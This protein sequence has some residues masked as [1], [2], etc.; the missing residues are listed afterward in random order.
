MATKL[1]PQTTAP[2]EQSHAQ[3]PGRYYRCPG[4]GDEV[5]GTNY[6]VVHLHQ[7]H[8]L[9]PHLFRHQAGSDE[10]DDNDR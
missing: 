3:E 7:L 5:D 6:G 9:H 8:V 10:R 2:G 1:N 4:C